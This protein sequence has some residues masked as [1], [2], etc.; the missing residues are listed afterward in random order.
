M[1]TI[2]RRGFLQ[3]AS[4]LVGGAYAHSILGGNLQAAPSFAAKPTFNP[5]A[6]FLT[7]Q[8]DPT[9]TMTVQWVGDEKE[10]ASRPIWYAKAGSDD[11]KSQLWTSRD[12][13]KTDAKSSAPN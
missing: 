11:W 5:E 9:T 4:L 6:L 3:S 8:R 2:S 7:W 13:P 1:S 10:A 12:F